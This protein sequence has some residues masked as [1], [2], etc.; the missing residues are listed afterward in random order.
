MGKL[1]Q[2]LEGH[3]IAAQGQR[4]ASIV[5]RA[6][7]VWRYFSTRGPAVLEDFSWWSGPTVRAARAGLDLVG[8]RL[9]T[10]VHDGRTYWLADVGAVRTEPQ[11]HLVTCYDEPV[12]AYSQSRDILHTVWARFKVP[13]PVDGFRHVLLLDGRLL[14]HWRATAGRAG[15]G[16]PNGAAAQPATA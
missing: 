2:T 11:V 9:E 7:L 1:A 6:E 4:L 16:G 12:I 14:G 8:A 10:Y 15:V 5:M 13:G 3:G